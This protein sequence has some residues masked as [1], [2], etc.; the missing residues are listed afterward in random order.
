MDNFKQIRSLLHFKDVGDFYFI[1]LLARKKDNP[2]LASHEK[3]IKSYSVYSLDEYDK[4][5]E[6]IKELCDTHNARA[7][8]RLNKRNSAHV[9]LKMISHLADSIHSKQTNS[10]HKIYNSIVGQYHSDE[11]KTWLI[12]VDGDKTLCM[13][14]VDYIGR[15]FKDITYV[16]II[17]TING[18]HVISK[19]F[20][21]REFRKKFTEIDIHKDNP[22]LLFFK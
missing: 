8:I 19:P 21:P 15:T 11:N 10:L 5:E 6:H 17:P 20:D 1:Q 7:Y 16:S 4:L 14:V 12:D 9:A 13:E 2:T 22:T 3:L 18:F